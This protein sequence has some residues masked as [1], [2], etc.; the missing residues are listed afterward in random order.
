MK[1]FLI[2]LTILVAFQ[3]EIFA[4]SEPAK[5]DVEQIKNTISLVPQYAFISGLRIDYERKLKNDDHWLVLAPQMYL[6]TNGNNGFND[7]DQM[8][9]FGMN[10]YFKM[11]LARS[12]TTN[13][14]NGFPRT[15]VYFSVGPTYQ[16]FNISNTGQIPYE[17]VENG[18]TYIRFETGEV[19]TIIN[20]YGGNANFGVQ[21]A[22]GSFLLDMY[23][24][25]GIRYALDS[26]GKLADI[27]NDNWI[28]YGYSG[29]L[30]DGGLRLGFY[31]P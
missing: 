21:F 7:Y 6:N 5:K 30:L 12:R 20:K 1:Y 14:T 27:Y 25:I 22:F 11:F 15:N 28:N 29:I 24:G 13:I 8:T 31:F 23:G 4:Q 26:E 2:S 3:T 18:I 9:G 17:V 10:V 19:S 16:H